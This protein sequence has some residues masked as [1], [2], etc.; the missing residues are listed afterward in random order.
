MVHVTQ[1]TIKRIEVTVG[2]VFCI[3]GE[4]ACNGWKCIRIKLVGF[5]IYQNVSL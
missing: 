3:A 2:L 5:F 4:D 1:K